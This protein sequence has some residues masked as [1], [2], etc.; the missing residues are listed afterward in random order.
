MAGD[1]DGT[2]RTF[3]EMVAMFPSTEAGIVEMLDAAFAPFPSHQR[4]LIQLMARTLA[5]DHVSI[6]AA[7]VDPEAEV[8]TATTNRYSNILRELSNYAPPHR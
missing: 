8:T 2:K 1:Q 3:E 7:G 5:R 4:A 6:M